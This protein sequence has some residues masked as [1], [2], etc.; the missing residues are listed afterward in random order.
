MDELIYPNIQ[1]QKV[2]RTHLCSTCYGPLVIKFHPTDRDSSIVQCHKCGENT[3]G[4]ITARSVS[5][6]KAQSIVDRIDA[7]RTLT[8]AGVIEKSKRSEADL[9]HSLGF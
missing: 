6:I 3:T 5:K 9:I 2:L 8:E 7:E 1:A 4:I